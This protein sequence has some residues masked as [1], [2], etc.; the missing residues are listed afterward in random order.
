METPEAREYLEQLYC[1]DYEILLAG[2]MQ[3]YTGTGNWLFR[4]KAFREWTQDRSSRIC[5]LRG[6]AGFGKT[7][8]A[9]SVVENLKMRTDRVLDLAPFGT[10]LV[11]HY[12]FREEKTGT[13]SQVSCLRSLLHQILLEYPQA[14]SVI[15]FNRVKSRNT[16]RGKQK[17]FTFTPDW[18]W[19]ALEDVLRMK[20]LQNTLLVLDALDEL[21]SGELFSMAEGLAELVQLSPRSQSIKILVFSRPNYHI[22][23]ILME[24]Q[25]TVLEV[26]RAETS[27]DLRTF[28]TAIVSEYGE[29]NNF[30]E[31]SVTKIQER[32]IEGADGMFLWAHLAWEH[33][34]QGVL[35]WNRAKI[36]AQLDSLGQLPRGLEELYRKIILSIDKSAKAELQPIFILICA[37]TRPLGTDEL[38]EILSIEDRHQK[39]SDIDVPFS[40]EGILLK[41]CPNLLRIDIDGTVVFVHLSLKDFLVRSFLRMDTTK[42]HKHIAQRCLK[43]LDFEDFK[44]DT[45]EDK[46]GNSQQKC[47]LRQRYHLYDYC[48]SS[49]K[50]H[51][52]Q[53]PYED[54]LWLRYSKIIRNRDVF[55]AIMMPDHKDHAPI[56]TSLDLYWAETPLRH[57]L[58]LKATE[59]VQTFVQSGYDINEWVSSGDNIHYAFETALH[60]YIRDQSIP[61][62]LLRLGADPNIKDLLDRNALHLAISC[63]NLELIE[64][65]LNHPDIDVNATDVAGETPL[66]YQV[67]SGA[68]PTLLFDRRI[69]VS[70]V[71]NSGITPMSK[72]AV[73]GDKDTFKRFINSPN[74]VLDHHNGVLSPL[75]CAAQQEWKDITLDLIMKIP[76]ANK[77]RGLDGKSIIHWAVI[78]NWDD[79][80]QA[81]IHHANAKINAMDDSGK[82]GLHYASQLGLDK[83]ARQ[84]LRYGA[85]ARIQDAAGRTAVHVAAIEGFADTLRPLIMESDVDPDDADEQ[86]RSLIHW[87]ASCDWGPIMTTVLDMPSID[88]LKRDHHG[89]TAFHIAALCGCPNILRILID[90]DTFDVT[91]TDA[92]GNTALH[93]AARGQSLTAVAIL[94]PHFD[95]HRNRVNEWSQTALDVAVNYGAEEIETTLIQAGLR[96]QAYSSKRS[97]TMREPSSCQSSSYVQTP[98]DL[99]LVRLSPRPKADAPRRREYFF[100]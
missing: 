75:V 43:Y 49:L 18:L 5:W 34:K 45:T 27:S 6:A 40:I 70:K 50:D 68:I 79:V 57:V 36:G 25:K 51:M 14:W 73:W 9:R 30:P 86:K 78:R 42:I 97:R 29:E 22:E 64:E 71:N 96:Y 44:S 1:V 55:H 33:F 61:M 88:P 89:R 63:N 53:L 17:E 54:S 32:I 99:S 4:S 24:K 93:L 16:P 83:I 12:F 20:G 8:I 66:H 7:V 65:L 23:N 92:F 11:L 26:G 13:L 48:T 59:L 72:S 74:F 98:D 31:A 76:E 87:A 41:H 62:L 77:H 10:S 35:V 56:N 28:I 46:I 47:L 21:R 2:S 69:D 95:I 52:E 84:L 85:S 100:P 94:L 39:A 19:G 81:A 91:D 67:V 3:P 37:A 58:R 38:G 80:L 90:H 15:D 60:R 82:T